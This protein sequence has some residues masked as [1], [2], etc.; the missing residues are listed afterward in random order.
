ME[1]NLPQQDYSRFGTKFVSKQDYPSLNKIKQ[2]YLGFGTRFVLKQDY[3]RFGTKPVPKQD[4]SSCPYV[5]HI[6]STNK[7]LE[8][9]IPRG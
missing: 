3:S 5:V 8:P 6:V 2:D 4:F 1:K 9:R 7:L